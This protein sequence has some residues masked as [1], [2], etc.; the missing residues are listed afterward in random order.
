M[1]MLLEVGSNEIVPK[2]ES[3]EKSQE[4]YVKPF[5]QQIKAE[6]TLV[7]PKVIEPES[8]KHQAIGQPKP[9]EKVKIVDNS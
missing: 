8:K 3:Q 2:P 5:D 9:T 7:K 4:V 1:N 6:E